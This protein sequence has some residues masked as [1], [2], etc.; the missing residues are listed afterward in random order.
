MH[1]CTAVHETLH[2]LIVLLPLCQA[3]V[4]LLYV[5]KLEV[6]LF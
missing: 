5:S 3:L 2:I 1:V 4:E 6:F